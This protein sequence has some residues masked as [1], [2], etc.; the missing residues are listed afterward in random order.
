MIL[1]SFDFFKA[2]SRWGVTDSMT[3]VF[4]KRIILT[5][6]LSLLFTTNM[7]LSAVAFW[8]F[9]HP[10]LAAFTLFFVLTEFTW[11]LLNRC[12]H[13]YVSRLGIL[14]SS[15]LLGFVV[16]V[17]LPGTNYNSGFFVMAGMPI[18]LFDLKERRSILL[19]L[20][21][22]MIL[23][24]ISE[25]AQ[26]NVSRMGFSLRL[27]GLTVEVIH[28]SIGV[29]YVAL[30]FLMFWFLSRE[31]ARSEEKLATALA[32][33]EAEKRKI[34]ELNFQLEE[35]RARAF[36]SAKFAALGEM[37]GGIAHEINNPMTVINLNAEQLKYMLKSPEERVEAAMAKLEVISK[38]VSR[39]A[40]II[41]S[42]RSFSRQAD[43][44]EFQYEYV[45]RIIDE[46]LSFCSERF[47]HHHIEM[48]VEYSEERVAIH[49]RPVQ[50]SQVILNLL[51]NAF[52]AIED[53]PQKWIHL[54]VIREEGH[55][56]ISVT[57]SGT[58]IPLSEQEKIFVPFYTT[59]AVGKGTGLGLSLSRKIIEDHGAQL[60]LDTNS[61][62]T[63][64]MIEFPDK[65]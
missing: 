39:V 65:A 24:P 17:L 26:F 45:Q 22:P 7:S 38:T 63:S 8:I 50:I 21:I 64:F 37:A 33:V 56:F 11:A 59:K 15:N 16:S 55:V 36:S 53:L 19:G 57:D 12:G 29:I 35:Q 4:A 3:P 62:N 49:C 13:Y 9:G 52:D 40:K 41:D 20:F 25:W 48:K 34:E 58:G 31:N 61:K 27:S 14:I 6:L 44:D 54:R 30:I 5:N 51:N 10:F 47:K 28:Y 2:V 1:K 60:R 42:M 46:T 43:E 32:N 23:Y 18:L